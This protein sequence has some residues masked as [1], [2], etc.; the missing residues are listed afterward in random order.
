MF[1]NKRLVKDWVNFINE[2]G[3]IN[4]GLDEET[5]VFNSE[6]GKE[7]ND[8]ED[9]K[10]HIINITDNTQ[11]A[12]LLIKKLKM[13]ENENYAQ[14]LIEISGNKELLELLLTLNSRY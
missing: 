1:S 7:D 14:A 13:P 9:L 11:G 12:S 5:A 3:I 4:S 8:L 6:L 10:N 2:N